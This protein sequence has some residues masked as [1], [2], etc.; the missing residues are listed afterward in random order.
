MFDHLLLT[1][2]GPLK[3]LRVR[4]QQR[5]MNSK[6]LLGWQ[7]KLNKCV[8]V[9]RIP[10]ETI[11]RSPRLGPATLH[12][13]LGLRDQSIDRIE[14]IAVLFHRHRNDR[15]SVLDV[16]IHRVLRRVVEERSHLIE[17]P[18]TDRIELV[19]VTHRTSHR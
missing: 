8:S 13:L 15:R 2:Q 1:R 14:S 10:Q 11:E 6:R 16:P 17:I 7:C 3:C 12:G 5:Q 19:I 18:L 9:C 4:S